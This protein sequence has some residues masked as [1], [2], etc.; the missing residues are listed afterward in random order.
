M[1]TKLV[2]RIGIGALIA[3]GIMILLS[4]H[5]YPDGLV[6][7]LFPLSALAGLCS[8]RG[9]FYPKGLSPKIGYRLLQIFFVFTLATFPISARHSTHL[10]WNVVYPLLGL[11]LC[12]GLLLNRVWR[13]DR[14]S[15]ELTSKA[16]NG[17]LLT[18]AGVSLIC[19]IPIVI[20]SLRPLG[21]AQEAGPL[22]PAL[23]EVAS[24]GF[25]REIPSQMQPVSEAQIERNLGHPPRE[26]TVA[27][28][29]TMM[30][31][32]YLLVFAVCLFFYFG[33]AGEPGLW[34]NEPWLVRSYGPVLAASVAVNIALA[35]L[36]RID[37]KPSASQS[38]SESI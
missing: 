23:W 25:G 4:A 6:T 14:E 1:Q 16:P 9:S 29:S 32:I 18:W 17:A 20:L 35:I 5:S 21:G 31:A 19:A 15:M 3:F 2:R 24:Y 8:I 13:V 38:N 34:K 10:L 12:S 36:L 30:G 7:V 33:G 22:V 11:M 27:M 26:I 28:G 37:A